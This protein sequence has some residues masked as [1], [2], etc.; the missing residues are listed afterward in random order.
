MSSKRIVVFSDL[1]EADYF[2]GRHQEIDFF[3]DILKLSQEKKKGHSILIQGSPWCWKNGFI[4]RIGKNSGKE[5][6][7]HCKIRIRYDGM[8]MNCIIV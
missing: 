6:L 1:G 7:D 2:H 5:R 8:P 4:T 3:K